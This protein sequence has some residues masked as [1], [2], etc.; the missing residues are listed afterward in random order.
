MRLLLAA[1]LSFAALATAASAEPSSQPAPE[2]NCFASSSW[3][4]W[5][6][7]D[8]GDA[9]YLR[10]RSDEVYRVDL[11]PGARVRDTPGRYLVSEVRGTG[12]IC[13]PLDLDLTLR[14]QVGIGRH[15]FVTGLRRLSAEEI[16]AIPRE[17]LPG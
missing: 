14:D 10:I 5:S 13:S 6:A 8:E 3:T 15:L 17:D 4:G 16:A 9:L 11:T 7:T 2:R 1:M 12:W